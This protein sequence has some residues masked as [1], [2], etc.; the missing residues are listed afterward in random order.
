MNIVLGQAELIQ[1][2]PNDGLLGSRERTISTRRGPTPPPVQAMLDGRLMTEP[3]PLVNQV[4]PGLACDF[5]HTLFEVKVRNIPFRKTPPKPVSQVML[6]TTML[7]KIRFLN[8]AICEQCAI[9][10]FK[11]L[12]RPVL[13]PGRRANY[14]Q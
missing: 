6:K 2:L 14:K 4:R 8:R 3:D 5:L 12:Q 7:P 10:G 11:F 13:R 9:I 1:A